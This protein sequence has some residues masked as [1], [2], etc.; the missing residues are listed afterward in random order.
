MRRSYTIAIKFEV[1]FLD[2]LPRLY[3]LLY[4]TVQPGSQRN[5]RFP[6]NGPKYGG[7]GARQFNP[8]SAGVTMLEPQIPPTH[9]V[10]IASDIEE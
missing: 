3:T 1:D 7:P 4:K 6:K 8:P 10:W 2:V 5:D 9:A